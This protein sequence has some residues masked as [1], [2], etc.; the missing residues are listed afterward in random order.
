MYNALTSA[1]IVTKLKASLSRVGYIKYLRFGD[2][3][4]NGRRDIGEYVL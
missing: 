2:I 1:P 4:S 3:S